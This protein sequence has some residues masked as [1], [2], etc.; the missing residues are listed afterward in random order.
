MSNYSDSHFN[1]K[2]P[3]SSWHKALKLIGSNQT[4]L[5]VGCS[6][7]NFGRVLIEQQNCVV[8]GVEIN[9]NDAKRARKYLREVIMVD[10]E[11]DDLSSLKNN[12]YDIIYFGDVIEHLVDPVKAIKRLAPKLNREGSIVFSVPNMAHIAV[13]LLLLKGEFDY[14]ET[15]LLDKTHL[16]FYTR[17][18]LERIFNE[19]DFSITNLKFVEKDYPESLIK[20]W[21][22]GL[23]LSGN[24][25]FFGAMKH[26]DAAAF[27][28][29]GAAKR[30]SNIKIMSSRPQFGPIDL[31]DSYH[32][33][34]TQDLNQ[35][36]LELQKENQ[37]LAREINVLKQ[38]WHNL[39]SHPVSFL[40]KV[41]SNKARSRK[42]S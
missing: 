16:H 10:V 7:G 13:R 27:Q 15:G 35:K 33:N 2:N 4:V 18:E 20:D 32:K 6:S 29:V 34:I 19:A 1:E 31:F 22:K 14:T 38:N 23:G 30:K 37:V 25:E 17:A 42:V 11:R 8:D 24:K 21:L 40:F 3:N 39:K 5:D 9:L 26:P 28:F 41:A 12:H 36:I